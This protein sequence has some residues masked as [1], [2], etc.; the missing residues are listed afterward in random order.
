[1]HNLASTY[2]S[3]GRLDEAEKLLVKT[4]GDRKM[5]LGASHPNTLQTMF[6]LAI[7]WYQL[8]HQAKA[9]SLMKVCLESQT[10]TLGAQHPQTSETLIVLSYFEAKFAIKSSDTVKDSHLDVNKIA[11]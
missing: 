1:M 7:T 9:I 3:L 11:N 4:L 2:Q 10:R 8:G 5:K 6:G